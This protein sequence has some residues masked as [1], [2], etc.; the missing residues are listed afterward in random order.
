MV[1]KYVRVY[2][3]LDIHVIKDHLLIFGDLSAQCAKCQ[4]MDININ[5]SLCPQCK[6]EFKYIAFRNIKSHLPKLQKLTAQRPSIQFID[7]D[8]Y[9]KE[10]DAIKARE[11]LK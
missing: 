3:K 5:E 1:E 7:Y 8:D 2:N 6:T 11:F 4:E 9:K 10:M